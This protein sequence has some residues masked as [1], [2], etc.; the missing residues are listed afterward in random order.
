MFFFASF[1]VDHIGTRVD[2]S[3]DITLLKRMYYAVKIFFESLYL[4][5][6]FRKTPEKSVTLFG[7]ARTDCPKKTLELGYNIGAALAKADWAVITGGGPGVMAAANKGCFDHGGNSIGC[8]IKLPSEQIPNNHTTLSVTCRF[9]VNR[10]RVLIANAKCFVALP[11]GYGTLDELF[12]VMTLVTTKQIKAI[13]I[14]LVDR[15]FWKPLLNYIDTTLTVDYKTVDP[16]KDILHVVDTPEELIQ[17]I[18][19]V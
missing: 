3:N 6:K 10:K 7:S 9:F 1:L 16:R 11:G 19:H 13:P 12:E 18:E 17:L 8:N 15:E 2:R 14:I 5:Y 4:L